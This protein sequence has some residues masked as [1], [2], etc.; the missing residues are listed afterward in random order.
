MVS[1]LLQIV[2]TTAASTQNCK[3]KLEKGGTAAHT[4]C[5]LMFRDTVNSNS[6]SSLS[7]ALEAGH[8]FHLSSWKPARPYAR[9]QKVADS[10]RQTTDLYTRR[11]I[12]LGCRLTYT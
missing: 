9:R 5:P 1:S 12:C 10:V 7:L 6:G 3:C 8:N 4:A 11:A 2:Q